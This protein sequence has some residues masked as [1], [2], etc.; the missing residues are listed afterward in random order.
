MHTDYTGLLSSQDSLV[1]SWYS[2]WDED[3]T[4]PENL[5]ALLPKLIL[6]PDDYYDIIASYL[7]IPSAL[8]RV[9]PHLFFF[10]AS[11]TGK[12][13]LSKFAAYWYGINLSSPTDTFAGIRNSLNDKKYK[14]IE[15]P[16]SDSSLPPYY[17]KV[18]VNTAMVYEDIDP[19]VLSTTP[20]LYRLL[21]VSNDRSTD[22]ISMSSET[23]GTNMEFYTFCPKIFS[24]ISAI[25]LDE[26]F[27]E[28]QRRLIVIPFKKIEDL[29]DERL[30]QLSTSRDTWQKHLI[31][32]DAYDWSNFSDKFI[33][34]WNYELASVY[35]LTRKTLAKTLTGLNSRH[36]AISLDLITTG[37]TSGIWSDEIAAVNKLKSYFDWY[38]KECSQYGGIRKYLTDYLANR[39]SGVHHKEMRNMIANWLEAGWILESPTA[40][41]LKEI[42]ADLGLVLYEGYWVK[43]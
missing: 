34:F 4:T 35:L 22:K 21:K 6:L 27:K 30:E 8:A 24:S 15:I 29:S 40:K 1:D 14:E 26:R 2:L 31:N 38:T 33:S 5:Q 20:N 16:N 18:E 36:R 17:K 12:T 23:K 42:L 13:T 32:I 41:Q 19:S 37:V 28:L 9:T 43:R 10:G 25:H 39:T 7:L 11:G 3:L